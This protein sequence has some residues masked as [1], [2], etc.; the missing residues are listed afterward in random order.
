MGKRDR[1][2]II[3]QIVPFST[4]QRVTRPACPRSTSL[5]RT[6][7]TDVPALNIREENVRASI[8]LLSSTLDLPA[9]TG[10]RL[11]VNIVINHYQEVDVFWVLFVGRNRPK[12]RN[13]ANS[14]K[15]G[16]RRNKPRRV[17]K[18][19]ALA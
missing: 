14:R 9:Q 10:Q 6:C 15:L 13:S 5:P 12:E 3:M 7:A 1:L 19:V 18:L 2:Q 4:I 16:Y 17:G 8:H 11:E